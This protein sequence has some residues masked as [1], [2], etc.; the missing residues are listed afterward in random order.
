MCLTAWVAVTGS[1]IAGDRPGGDL[2]EL[3]KPES[4]VLDDSPASNR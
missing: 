1:L 2:R 4:G 3:A